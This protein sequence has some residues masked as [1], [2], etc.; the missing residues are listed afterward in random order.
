MDCRAR[1]GFLFLRQ[2]K[3]R[4]TTALFA[5]RQALCSAGLTA[6]RHGGSRPPSMSFRIQW[7]WR[8]VLLLLMA[9]GLRAQVAKPGALGVDFDDKTRSPANMASTYVPLDSWVYAAIYRL[10]AL[11]YVQTAFAGVR[12]WTRMECAR[13]V[14]EA[15]ERTANA[16]PRSEAAALYHS[17][18]REFTPELQRLDGAANVGFQVESIYSQALGISGQPLTD[19]Y[20]FAQ[21]LINNF[22]RPYGEGANVYAGTAL[23]GVAGPL[24]VYFRGEYQQSGSVPSPSAAAQAAIAKADSTPAASAGP[25]SNLSR[26]R[27]IDAYAAWTF[28]NNQISFGK[29]SL[30]WGPGL[31]DAM[32]FSDNA[33]SIP[34]LRYDRVSPFKLPGF[35]G[36]IG[37]M[38]VGFFIG[39][40][41]GQ[42]F[43]HLPNGTSPGQPGV[44]LAN[45]PYIHGMKLSVRPTPNLEIGFS[46]SVIFGGPGFPVTWA[47]FWRSIFSAGSPTYTF[48]DPGDSRQAF[49]ISYRVPGLRDWLTLYC[50]SFADDEVFP[51]AF[52]T[53]SAWGPG[54]Y[55]PKLPHLHKMDFRAEGAITPGRLFPGFF[56]Y[57]IHYLDGYTNDRELMGSWIGRQGSGFQLQSTYWFSGR[58]TLQAGYRSLWVDHSFLQG[59]WL[60]DYSVGTNIRLSE[61]F[62]LQALGQYEQWRFPLLTTNRVRNMTTSIQLSYTPHRS[63][64]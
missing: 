18:A 40:L 45:Q 31:G 43:V 46:R 29:Q 4:G 33:E 37:P 7:C 44:S 1:P 12:P 21:T 19:G 13:L 5:N 61:N 57:N 41:A 39:R 56:Y 35:L 48:S 51:P 50:D 34:M 38:R 55:L 63:A 30:W 24:A 17:L 36:V 15:D 2:V 16:D 58:S 8:F 47:S 3:G 20:H 64:P 25:A 9:P 22:G 10:E 14:A 32:Q 28:K 60:K 62:S 42:Q 27:L 53:H 52:P 23:R 59:G 54:V 26:F 11:G 49:D 6:D